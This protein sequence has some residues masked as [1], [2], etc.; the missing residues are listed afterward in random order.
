MTK[1]KDFKRRV[2]ARMAKT[3]ESYT[4]ARANLLD[5][6]DPPGS[7]N[8]TLPIPPHH[9]KLAGMSD[10]KV[11]KATGK[12]WTA[13]A[14]ALDGVGAAAW[15]HR[16]IADHL[17]EVHGV[18]DWWTQMVTVGYERLR[19]LRDVGQ[20]RGGSYEVNKS[21]TLAVPVADV[22]DAFADTRRR[23][24]WLPDLALR[25]TTA[26]KPKS[27]RMRLDDDSRLE[28]YFM[29]KGPARASVSVQ[30]RKLVDRETAER[31]R[32]FWTE[33]LEV[34]KGLLEGE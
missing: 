20:R 6:T 34:L 18:P 22:F 12:T 29:A 25:V 1:Q 9:E 30:H 11:E 26:T 16:A 28:A 14:A 10:Q 15:E 27:I 8:R 3:G 24:K 33:R 17:R 31:T 7:G 23:K 21:K 19:G 5:A 13:W 32:T 2:R 4:A